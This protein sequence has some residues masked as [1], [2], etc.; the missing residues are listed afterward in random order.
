LDKEACASHYRCSAADLDAYMASDMD[1]VDTLVDIDSKEHALV[2]EDTYRV[3]N[4]E[5]ADNCYFYCLKVLLFQAGSLNLPFCHF[6]RL[7]SLF[8]IFHFHLVISHD[9]TDFDNCSFE[10]MLLLFVDFGDHLCLAIFTIRFIVY[11]V[12]KS[13][14]NWFLSFPRS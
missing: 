2:G 8:K 1:K 5:D 12:N 10:S 4:K 9:Y 14:S 11:V 6:F 13:I 7:S 3:G